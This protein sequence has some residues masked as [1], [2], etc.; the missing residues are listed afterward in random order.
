MSLGDLRH[1]VDS[2]QRRGGT[3]AAP[4]LPL[5]GDGRELSAQARLCAEPL[6]ARH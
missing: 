2:E 5:R 4:P 3:G 6:P 1:F